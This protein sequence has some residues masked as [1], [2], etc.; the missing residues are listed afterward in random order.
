MA[1]RYCVDGVGGPT[2]ICLHFPWIVQ[3]VDACPVCGRD[4]PSRSSKKQVCDTQTHRRYQLFTDA[5]FVASRKC[6][7]PHAHSN[8]P[9]QHKHIALRDCSSLRLLDSTC[10]ALSTPA[11]TYCAARL[12]IA[13]SYGFHLLCT[14]HPPPTHTLR[15][16]TVVLLWLMSA[17][18]CV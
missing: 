1:F 9:P 4:V 14:L 15:C 16:E 11:Q 7:L 12:C 17:F 3:E 2:A 6:P 5:G 13:V 8:P 18:R 10:N